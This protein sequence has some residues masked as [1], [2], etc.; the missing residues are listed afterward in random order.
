MVT[1]IP[2]F[3]SASVIIPT[4]VFLVLVW[5][6]IHR[7]LY[8]SN[9]LKKKRLEISIATAGVLVGW[10]A[11]VFVL[12]NNG[13]FAETPVNVPTELLIGTDIHVPNILFTFLLIYG[14][15]I[16]VFFS[17][18]LQPVFDDLPQHWLIGIQT[19]R[20][21]GYSFLTLY[22]MGLLPGEF[23]LP[24]GYGDMI[25]GFTAP[26]VAYLFFLKKSYSKMLAI[27]WNIIG[28]LDLVVAVV[29]GILAYPIPFQVL[30]T[31]VSTELLA[32]FPLVMIPA[33]AV[34]LAALLHLAS[35]R[36]LLKK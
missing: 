34:P 7:A 22:S 8:S 14:I 33:F 31:E 13:F 28:I 6:I 19:Y 9:I 5:I 26:L 2:S 30:S 21:A 36:V 17:K 16:I 25:V 20:I 27:A 24:S 15:I 10:F 18:T 12:G 11:I 32:L 35:L 23:A 4:F 29:I 1:E 3:L